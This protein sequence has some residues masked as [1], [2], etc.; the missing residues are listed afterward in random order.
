M[1]LRK[2]PTLR[3]LMQPR[4]NELS[5]AKLE[6]GPWLF[7]QNVRASSW[8]LACGYFVQ[9]V[10]RVI[11]KPRAPADPDADSVAFV[12]QQCDKVVE[13]VVALMEK[14]YPVA[15]LLDVAIKARIT[16]EDDTPHLANVL[17]GVEYGNE[18]VQ[19]P[20]HR[21]GGNGGAGQ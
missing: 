11:I 15:A 8:I 3:S 16:Y 4:P 6:N 10:K 19:R 18:Q 14:G 1:P 5:P 12:K 2:L 21:P 17:R 9:V 20:N 13:G 7:E